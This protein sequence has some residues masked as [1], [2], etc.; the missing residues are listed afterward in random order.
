MQPTVGTRSLDHR[1]LQETEPTSTDLPL[2]IALTRVAPYLIRYDRSACAHRRHDTPVLTR[3][4]MSH[5]PCVRGKLSMSAR[6]DPRCT[7]P[8]VQGM[9]WMTIR[10]ACPAKAADSL[11]PQVAYTVF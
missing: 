6:N 1:R 8:A 2:L 3:L 4:R 7:D 10:L 11:P 5:T 9:K